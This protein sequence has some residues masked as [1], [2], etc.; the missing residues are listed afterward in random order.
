MKRYYLISLILS[1]FIA[2]TQAKI[3]DLNITDAEAWRVSH[4][5]DY[6]G[7]TVHFIQPIY[8]LNNYYSDYLTVSTRHLY[9][10]T[11]QCLPGS[12][13]MA[14]LN[15]NNNY[16]QATLTGVGGY[17]RMTERIDGLVAKITN[18]NQWQ[19]I[20]ADKWSGT[21]DDYMLP[22]SVDGDSTHRLLICAWNLEY[23]LAQNFGTGFGPDD[24]EAHH[25]QQT[26][27]LKALRLIN[28]DIYGF[29][30]IEQGQA[31]LQELSDSLGNKYTFV[32]DHG[33]AYSSYVKVGY[34]YDSTKVEVVGAL[35]NN[36]VMVS[37]RKKMITFR[38]KS[39]GESFIFSLN[40]FKAKSGSGSGLDA[41]QGDGQ[42]IFNYT[43]TKEAY[44]VIDMYEQYSK[45]IN[46]TDI[47]VMGDLNAY[48]KEDP[49]TAFTDA[50]YTD[51]H[52]AF[53]ADSSYSYN[54]HGLLGYLDHA[55]ANTS[56]YNQ[57]TGMQAWHIN[58]PE[59]DKFTYD[60]SDDL[61]MFRS[62]DHDPILVGLRLFDQSTAVK[63]VA[64]NNASVLY[65]NTTPVIM[66]AEGG[67]YRLYNVSGLL[68]NQGNIDNT[69][70]K[71]HNIQNGFYILDI[72]IEGKRQQ[73]KLI[74][75]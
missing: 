15:S 48:A 22:P 16:S 30:E 19:Y 74:I 54:W 62:S 69:T 21:R 34:V 71:L 46:E 13:Q 43:R 28:A 26:K 18:Y 57:I 36:D 40:H 31:A 32:N 44:S 9:S 51:L 27:I 37:H 25:R 50:G 41:D 73:F 58:S 63:N 35:Q 33:V 55:I 56:M 3:I 29:L 49:I 67:W 20:S 45:K 61:T 4:M 11:N 75:R 59:H 52:R 70:Y 8:I 14:T 10:P 24:A 64:V 12:S 38:E 7:D 47:L 2:G 39:T 53:H 5:D 42:G 1:I 72:F 65:E 23:Y 68:V 6:I 60:K 17:H 66:N